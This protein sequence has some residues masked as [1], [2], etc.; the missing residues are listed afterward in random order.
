MLQPLSVNIDSQ[1]FVQI[2]VLY[3]NHH[4]Q[5]LTWWCSWCP[6][7]CKVELTLHCKYLLKNTGTQKYS[8]VLCYV[9]YTTFACNVDS[10]FPV[11]I[12]VIIIFSV[13]PGGLPGVQSRTYIAL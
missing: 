6:W 7:L 3:C 1:F 8:L 4:L 2:T 9:L 10:Q 11:Q 13:S 5:C 12:T